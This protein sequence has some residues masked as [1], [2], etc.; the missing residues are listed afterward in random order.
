MTLYE[1][2][3]V[4]YQ[5]SYVQLGYKVAEFDFSIRLE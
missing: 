5:I 4:W 3:L 2:V 1:M